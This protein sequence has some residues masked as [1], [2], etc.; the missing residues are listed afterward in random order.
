MTCIIRA[1]SDEDA[2]RIANESNYGLVGTVHSSDRDRASVWL[3]RSNAGVVTS[4]ALRPSDRSA[5]GSRAAS[6]VRAV[7]AGI[8]SYTELRSVTAFG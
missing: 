1:T 8:R 6:V 3:A 5:V 2:I 7:I 4:T